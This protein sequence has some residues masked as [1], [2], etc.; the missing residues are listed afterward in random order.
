MPTEGR[1]PTRLVALRVSS[2]GHASIVLSHEA[3]RESQS[4]RRELEGAVAEKGPRVRGPGPFG[5]LGTCEAKGAGQSPNVGTGQSL[6]APGVALWEGW[7]LCQAGLHGWGLHRPCS[8][9]C[10]LWPLSLCVLV[11]K[12]GTLVLLPHRPR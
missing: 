5:A 3:A 6:G 1:G 4:S 12:T 9:L 7:S 8:E 2:R 11:Y 10:A